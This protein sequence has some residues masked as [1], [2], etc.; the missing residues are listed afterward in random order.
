[1]RVSEVMVPIPR[2]LWS[3]AM[4]MII[5]F[6][7]TVSACVEY[8]VNNSNDTL[9]EL[10]EQVQDS[11]VTLLN[12]CVANNLM[13][14]KGSFAKRHRCCYLQPLLCWNP[15]SQ[16]FHAHQPG[17]TLCATATAVLC[18][19]CLSHFTCSTYCK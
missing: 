3:I 11:N 17:Y 8:M 5:K 15:A 18:Q 10:L 1:V 9:L 13:T 4:L 7:P 16:A 19:F 6:S 14:L 12:L 2:T